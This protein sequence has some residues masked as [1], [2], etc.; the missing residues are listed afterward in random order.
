[1]CTK[2]LLPKLLTGLDLRA[3]MNA[4]FCDF[5]LL[6]REEAMT[7]QLVLLP[8][9]C[10]TR[11]NGCRYAQCAHVDKSRWKSRWMSHWVQKYAPN[12]FTFHLDPG[13]RNGCEIV[14]AKR[15]YDSLLITTLNKSEQVRAKRLYFSL[16]CLIQR[17]WV[18]KYA[19]NAFTFHLDICVEKYSLRI[20]VKT[21]APHACAFHWICTVKHCT[22]FTSNTVNLRRTGP[23]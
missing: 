21:P 12:A 5:C 20:S 11:I 16:E 22:H 15:L 7:S 4:Q 23:L 2:Q 19:P 13:C 18:K 14:C 10:V 6:R 8:S 3:A 1:M 9:R 17:I